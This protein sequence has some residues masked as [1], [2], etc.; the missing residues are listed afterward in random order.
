MRFQIPRHSFKLSPEFRKTAE[1]FRV[2]VWRSCS[3]QHQGNPTKLDLRTHSMF[4]KSIICMVGQST[5][6]LRS[7]GEFTI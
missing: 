3:D 2:D 6:A 4:R 5:I 1:L 7:A